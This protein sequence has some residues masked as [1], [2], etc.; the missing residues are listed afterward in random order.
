MSD[1]RLEV[2][3]QN[4]HRLRQH[5]PTVAQP[6]RARQEAVQAEFQA[7]GAALT[8]LLAVA[9]PALAVVLHSIEIEDTWTASVRPVEEPAFRDRRPQRFSPPPAEQGLS[10]R[11]AAQRGVCLVDGLER[12]PLSAPDNAPLRRD[13]SGERV[14]YAAHGVFEGS[15][16]Y[17]LEDGRLAVGEYAGRW[18]EAPGEENFRAMLLTL[19][20]GPAAWKPIMRAY[21]LDEILAGMAD[22]FERH[23]KAAPKRMAHAADALARAQRYRELAVLIKD[24]G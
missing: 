2:L 11:F 10:R 1:D 22:L 4:A 12:V 7:W 14:P 20:D 13:H 16:L 5:I 24:V 15:A 21:G 19:Y 18:N 23:A 6:G 17:L 3:L 8:E 9:A